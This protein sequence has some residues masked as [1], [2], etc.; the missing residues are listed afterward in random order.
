MKKAQKARCELRRKQ[1]QRK[2]RVQ[3]DFWC[4][5]IVSWGARKLQPKLEP[6]MRSCHHTGL[7]LASEHTSLCLWKRARCFSN[8]DETPQPSDHN[9][10]KPFLRLFSIKC[11]IW[12]QKF[13]IIENRFFLIV[14]DYNSWFRSGFFQDF[15]AIFVTFL[16]LFS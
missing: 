4:S 2:K 14:V 10:L 12:A 11:I 8:T 16:A 7:S 5:P 3:G 9:I 1:V 6:T 13:D 15:L